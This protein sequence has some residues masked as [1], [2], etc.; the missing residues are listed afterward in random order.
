[1]GYQLNYYRGDYAAIGGTNPFALLPITNLPTLA[2]N[3]QTGADLFNGNIGSMLVNIPKLGDARLYGY[4]YDQLN[5]IVAM[6]S[7][8]GFSGSSNTL[9]PQVGEEYKERISYD[10]NGNILTYL[11]NGNTARLVMDNMTYSYVPSTNKLDKV[12]DAATDA[13]ASEYDKYGDI[14]QGQ[15]NGNYVYDAIGNLVKDVQ[16]GITNIE[17]TVYGKIASINKTVG[18]TNTQI[19]YTYDAGGNRI[20]KKVVTATGTTTT[21]QHTWYVRDIKGNVMAIYQQQ[22]A[23]DLI[24]TEVYLNGNS[25]LGLWLGNKNVNLDNLAIQKD[26]AG[27]GYEGRLERG[28]KFF[29]LSN[30]LGNVLVTVSDRKLQF[31]ATLNSTVVGYYLPDVV[32]A[33]DYYPFGMGMAGRK[34]SASGAY[35]YGF[36]GKEKDVDINSLT[37]YDYGFRIYNPAIGK[38]LS[39]DPLTK[40]YP[41]YTPYQFAGNTPIQAVDLDGCEEIHYVFV[42]AR[43]EFGREAVMKLGGMLIGTPT[44]KV[45][46]NGMLQYNEPY[47]IYAHYPAQAFGEMHLVTATYNSEEEFQKAKASDFYASAITVGANRGAEIA[48]H[49]GDLLAIGYITS[50]LAFVGKEAISLFVEQKIAQYSSSLVNKQVL[51]QL[52]SQNIRQQILKSGITAEAKLA[53]MESGTEG[54]HFLAR[55]GAQTTLQQQLTRATTGLTPD[56]VAGRAVASSRFLTHELQLE[57]L[58]MAE[59]AYVPGMK[60]VTLDMGKVVGEGYLKGGGAVKTS[61]SVQVYYNSNGEII[62]LFPKLIK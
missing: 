1:M 51:E 41:W 10:P 37:A 43:D 27:I 6:N 32:T 35:R 30:H 9:T 40:S 39:V 58:E 17:W 31:A 22:D 21:T 59:A 56:G 5:R 33:N 53:A 15:A 52:I 57:A 47:K 4:R 25:R 36:N 46:K 55:H 23:T 14:K 26:N 34:F 42:W 16:A 60:E 3:V 13:A 11:R 24:Q 62:T 18:A 49:F 2:D 28:N 8:T 7:Y 19:S 61:T 29:E 44:G 38:F 54:A 12:T 48:M 45:D 50:S 20:S